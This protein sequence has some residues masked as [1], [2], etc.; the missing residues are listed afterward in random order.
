MCECDYDYGE[1]LPSKPKPDPFMVTKEVLGWFRRSLT[2]A[3]GKWTNEDERQ[4][5]RAWTNL[6]TIEDR[7]KRATS[8]LEHLNG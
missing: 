3:Q 7:I 8:L 4:F 5:A 1:L 6:N 2:V